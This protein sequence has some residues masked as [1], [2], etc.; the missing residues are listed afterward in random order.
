MLLT[1]FSPSLSYLRLS[2]S[3]SPST[4][5]HSLS[6]LKKNRPPFS[7]PRTDHRS[8]SPT[9]VTLHRVQESIA[10]QE[11]W[12]ISNQLHQR[13]WPSLFLLAFISDFKVKP[14][15]AQEQRHWPSLFLLAFISATDDLFLSFLLQK[16]VQVTL[17]IPVK[18]GFRLC[19]NRF[20]FVKIEWE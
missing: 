1:S 10:D 8:S 18:I 9:L 17:L 15:F 6:H 20:L 13:H 14:L 5:R 4:F 3:P 19:W 16:S 7:H 12:F 2:I 11:H